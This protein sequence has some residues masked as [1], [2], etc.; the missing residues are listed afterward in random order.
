MSKQD[1]LLV[2]F[3]ENNAFDLTPLLYKCL[4]FYAR[5]DKDASDSSKRMIKILATLKP[6]HEV[7]KMTMAYMFA[8]VAG[9]LSECQSENATK[10]AVIVLDYLEN[11]DSFI[12]V[13]V[14]DELLQGK[15]EKHRILDKIEEIELEQLGKTKKKVVTIDTGI[16]AQ[17][18][19]MPV[20][21]ALYH[22]K[23]T[24]R[25]AAL[26]SLYQQWIEN[27]DVTDGKDLR[28]IVSMLIQ[29][30]EQRE[31]EDVLIVTLT[32]LEYLLKKQLLAEAL[33]NQLYTCLIE[34]FI[35]K[36]FPPDRQYS[37]DAY[38]KGVNLFL[39]LKATAFE[40][41]QFI[42]YTICNLNDSCKALLDETT[43]TEN[44]S[45]EGEL[46]ADKINLEK[47]L[48]LL[49]LLIKKP[50]LSCLEDGKIWSVFET[51]FNSILK[52]SEND[53]TICCLSLLSSL[54]EANLTH[55]VENM[56][57]IVSLFIGKL[58]SLSNSDRAPKE[59]L[60]VSEILTQAL[61]IHQALIPTIFE[62]IIIK[63]LNC[64][65]TM[66]VDFFTVLYHES[67]ENDS[68]RLHAL[69]FL[70]RSIDR[71]SDLDTRTQLLANYL[72]TFLVALS[73]S[74]VNCRKLAMDIL[75]IYENYE[76]FSKIMKKE[77]KK[78]VSVFEFIINKRKVH[79]I[80]KG[81]LLDNL[82]EFIE[83]LTTSHETEITSDPK[84][85]DNLIKVDKNEALFEYLMYAISSSRTP[86]EL[87]SYLRL[88]KSQVL[89]VNQMEK[90]CNVLVSI[91][92]KATLLGK[93]LSFQYMASLIEILCSQD[94]TQDEVAYSV[95]DCLLGVLDQ[96]NN[97]SFDLAENY[98]L[99]ANR[100][101]VSITV[102][103]AKRNSTSGAIFDKI[104]NLLG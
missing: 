27:E 76:S 12:Y 78:Q 75:K 85:I 24:V 2:F 5:S 23:K 74:E 94:T 72:P 36:H 15:N 67:K 48:E 40:D 19:S 52:K 25:K 11:R 81:N 4:E 70:K 50:E 49:S 1:Q 91:E 69:L 7:Y 71:L 28:M 43:F 30:I 46:K 90:F 6:S 45:K 86:L 56:K 65:V 99:K 92:F 21:L 32:L 59:R 89:K 51:Y 53:P 31:T 47:G 38:M 34:E 20:L 16:S 29:F 68:V 80:K 17:K 10:F 73:D 60:K 33:I 100:K 44:L 58:P 39:S 62:T 3:R 79:A 97:K 82:E 41:T 42:V 54:K 8:I 102:E 35:P 18:D 101:L 93:D 55:S 14:L 13:Q 64:D 96:Y 88:L 77:K 9:H 37:N 26:L 98:V 83:E 95:H 61:K 104:F 84:F 22:K 66:M 57:N 63:H 87:Q 103:L